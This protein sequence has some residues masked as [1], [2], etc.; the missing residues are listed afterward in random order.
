MKK[1]I[2]EALGTAALVFFGCGAAVLA[3][4]EVGHLGI[5]FAFGLSVVAMA[6]GVGMVSGCHI[7]PAV[8]FG[9]FAAGRLSGAEFVRYALAQCAGAIVGAAILWAVASG[10][11]DYSLA[12]NGLGQNGWGPGYGGGYTLTSAFIFELVA[13]FAFLVVILGVT[14]KNAP[15]AVAGLAIGLTLVLI[16]IVGIPV[17]G[18]SVNPARSLG[19]AVFTQ[20][21]ALEQLW[22]FVVA[23]LL[24]A[25][26]AGL[27]F[28]Q[29]ILETE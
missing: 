6:Y 25:G 15:A 16:H 4:G 26:L 21:Q 2:A 24:G 13:T 20:G 27:L 18:V 12:L 14:Q 29:K 17:T 22:L 23:P 5:S 11:S 10:K 3:G 1:L 19:P 8:S 7:N 9:L 28:K